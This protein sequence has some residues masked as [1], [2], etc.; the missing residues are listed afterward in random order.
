MS[1]FRSLGERVRQ[2]LRRTRELMDDGLGTILA[3][4]RPI[5]D[6]MLDE[7][8]ETL[9]AAD[10]GTGAAAAFVQQVRDEVKRGRIRSS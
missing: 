1:L 6:S 10:L 4:A 9:I 3:I 2:G 7:L 5:D 8:E